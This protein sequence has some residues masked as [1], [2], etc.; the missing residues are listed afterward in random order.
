MPLKEVP[1]SQDSLTLFFLRKHS[2]KACHS[3]VT[4]CTGGTR[5][6]VEANNRFSIG[7]K[8][9]SWS[10]FLWAQYIS[11]LHA[12]LGNLKESGW[13]LLEITEL[14]G[15]C[16]SAPFVL[17]SKGF[18]LVTDQTL[19]QSKRKEHAHHKHLW[20]SNQKPEKLPAFA[21]KF[22]RSYPQ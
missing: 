7:L 14:L 3:I 22:H 17:C 5:T 16:S 2:H 9:V 19:K 10:H 15:R 1:F 12:L 11:F 4:S 6:Y 13:T 8:G 21:L 18:M 20:L